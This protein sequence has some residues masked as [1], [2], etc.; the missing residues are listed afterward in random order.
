M[1]QM[2]EKEKSPISSIWSY[3]TKS[4]SGL[5]NKRK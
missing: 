1:V 4:L 2:E 5:M 3:R